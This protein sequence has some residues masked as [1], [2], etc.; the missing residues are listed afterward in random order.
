MARA[1][2]S[3]QVN[4]LL[5]R[6]DFPQAFPLAVAWTESAPRSPAAWFARARCAF[7]IGRLVAAHEAVDQAV[8]LGA[9][10]HDVTLLR[11]VINHRL[12]RSADAIAALQALIQQRAP[13]AS[14]AMFALAEALYRSNRREELED[15]LSRG[16]D[17]LQDSRAAI[18]TAR[19]TARADRAGTIDRLES[20][21]RSNGP[22][23]LRRIA[24]FDAVR[25]L[26]ADA[27]YRRA[28]DLA[29]FLHASTGSVFDVE[30]LLEDVRAQLTLL[31]R[32]RPWFEPSIPPQPGVL[33]VVGVP[34]S[35]TT[36]LEQ[37]LDRHPAICG[38]GE[39][40]GVATLGAELLGRGVWP[41]G[42]D[43]LERS[44]AH[45]LRE[46]YLAGALISRRSGASWTFDK[47]LM[48]WRY[49]PAVAAVLRGAVCLRMQR[50]ARDTAISIFL[51][52]FHPRAFGW[53]S[54][55][56]SIRSVIAA[57]RALAPRALEVLGL[58]HEEIRYES[59]VE[60]PREHMERVLSRL[61][62][63]MDEAT[64]TPEANQRT[65]L[66]LSHE[67]VRRSINRS[68]IGRWQNY[69]W[70]F[71]GSWDELE[72]SHER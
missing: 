50:A 41:A 61:G 28:F 15:L 56:D 46:R 71:D 55:L 67:Q 18:F 49:L 6:H 24:G 43:Q 22:A 12:G 1:P 16:G 29:T 11:A 31:E 68:S 2:V 42:L 3:S 13:N 64:L 53:T 10:G 4:D 58:S 62:L 40:E 51:G 33:L 35:G 23:H 63:P 60:S 38:I 44:D 19:I 66:T 25:L 39:Y 34:R 52:N 26:D 72:R 54:S 48:T 21:A 7:G 9:T 57:E 47:S 27:Q 30:G 14:D 37:M 59:L 8:R 65:V 69:A 17:W 36:L 45:R 70:A 32:G 20:L 5:A